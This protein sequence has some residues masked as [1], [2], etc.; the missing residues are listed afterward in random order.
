MWRVCAILSTDEAL[1]SAD[2][3]W[4]HRLLD[5]PLPRDEAREL[6]E[7]DDVDA[8]DGVGVMPSNPEQSSPNSSA[9]EARESMELLQL[10]EA[11]ELM[12][13]MVKSLAM[14]RQ[15]IF[16]GWCF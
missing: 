15:F 8:Y 6:E 13:N 11:E 9:F 5:R 12:E 3:L 10:S 1:T 14:S 4:T 2:R 16:Y 7:E